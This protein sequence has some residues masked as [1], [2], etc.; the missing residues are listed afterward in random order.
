VLMPGIGEIVG[1][2]MRNDD[3]EDLV[4]QYQKENIPP[5]K[6]YWSGTSRWH[7]LRW[8]TRPPKERS[9]TVLSPLLSL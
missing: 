7:L 8:W 4:R 2:S 6:Y 5:E 1:G 3:Y 9:M